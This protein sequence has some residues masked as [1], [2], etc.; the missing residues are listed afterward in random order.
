[1]KNICNIL[2]VSVSIILFNSCSNIEN[3]AIDSSKKMITDLFNNNDSFG[4][5]VYRPDKDT[6]FTLIRVYKNNTMIDNLIDGDETFVNPIIFYKNK[7]EK[8]GTLKNYEILEMEYQYTLFPLW[9]YGY[10]HSVK[11][12]LTCQYNE[13]KTEEIITVYYIKEKSG[14]EIVDYTIIENPIE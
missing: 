2:L 10:P 5:Y 4:K 3:I 11:T 12:K 14:S 9:D 7:K 8:Y 6:L 1:M 13:M